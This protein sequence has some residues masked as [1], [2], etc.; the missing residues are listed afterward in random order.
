[1]KIVQILTVNCEVMVNLKHIESP[2]NL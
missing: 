1:M 2:G